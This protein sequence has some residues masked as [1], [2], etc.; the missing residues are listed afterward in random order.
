MANETKK[1]KCILREN[2]IKPFKR[3]NYCEGSLLRCFSFR[4]TIVSLVVV[5]LVYF[6]VDTTSATERLL[7]AAVVLLWAVLVDLVSKETDKLV[8]SEY[9][10]KEALREKALAE[11]RYQR[12]FEDA[13][14]AI[15]IVEPETG[16]V[17]DCN[18]KAT[19]MLGYKK[20][21]LLQMTVYDINPPTES[22]NITERISRQLQN[23]ALQ[24]Q[25]VH[26]AKDGRAIDVEVTSKLIQ[27]QERKVLQAFVRDI[28]LRK[29]AERQQADLLKLLNETIENM[30]DGIFLLDH[31]HTVVLANPHAKECLKHCG[32]EGTGD[33]LYTIEGRPVEEFLISPPKVYFHEVRTSERI[34]EIASCLCPKAKIKNY[35]IK[36]TFFMLIILLMANFGTT[37]AEFAGW[38]ASMEIFG[39]SKYIT[40]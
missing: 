27:W 37:V 40:V 23:E 31:E 32:V 15:Y 38:A 9:L 4:F 18:K 14:D 34:F 26:I 2:G 21:E 7:M 3:C 1:G 35:G 11:E 5:V 29:E 20:E 12:L 25:T 28:S 36:V 30:P 19:E 39:L 22:G 17:L 33:S 8:E 24:F 16:R 6:L 10:A 13:S